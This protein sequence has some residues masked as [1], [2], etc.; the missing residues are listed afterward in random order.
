ML[1][2][3][4]CPSFNDFRRARALDPGEFQHTAAIQVLGM[5][6]PTHSG[7]GGARPSLGYMARYGVTEGLDVG[8]KLEPL[9]GV[10]VNTTAQITHGLVDVAFGPSLG[11]LTLIAPVTY[12]PRSATQLANSPTHTL[13]A[14][15]LPILVGFNLRGGHQLV[16]SPRLTGWFVQP[17]ASQ[18]DGSA[19]PGGVEVLGGGTLGISFKMMESVHVMPAFSFTAPVAWTGR[20]RETCAGAACAPIDARALVV[21]G[22][23]G[24]SFDSDILK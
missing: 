19:V 8:M 13:V 17:Q 5:T 15:T 16:V 6:A 1:L 4:G 2:L 18:V 14:S 7:L 10:E 11:Y 24:I 21:Q 20:D 9:V 3:T 23:L 22:G 12:G